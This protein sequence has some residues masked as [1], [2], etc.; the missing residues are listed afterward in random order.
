MFLPR[1]YPD[2]LVGSLL[3]RAER[4]LG[5]GREQL[6]MRLTSHPLSS[7][8][9]LMTPYAGVADAFGLPL[10]EFLH[11]HTVFPYMTAFLPAPERARAL[12]VLVH[13]ADHHRRTASLVRRSVMGKTW[14]RFCPQCV[15]EE[16][17]SYGESYWHRVHQV[18]GVEVCVKHDCNLCVTPFRISRDPGIA[19]PHQVFDLR[20]TCVSIPRAIAA[21]VARASADALWARNGLGLLPPGYP[22]RVKELGYVYMRSK[23]HGALLAHDLK[24]FFGEQYLDKYGC[25]VGTSR[26]GLWPAKLLHA[27]GHHAT[28][29]KHIL[30][31]VFLDS[32]PAPS[33]SRIEFEGRRKPKPRDWSQVEEDAITRMTAEVARHKSAGTRISLEDLHHLAGVSSIV[34]VHWHR[35]PRLMAWLDDFRITPQSARIPGRRPRK[36]SLIPIRLSEGEMYGMGHRTGYCK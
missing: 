31:A 3:H 32:V 14:L 36:D 18:T 25:A 13:A 20:S 28:T 7:H 34:R 11:Q 21:A 4:Q 5:I 22:E 16:L 29:F 9:F 26:K 19:P 12:S 15:G 35:V 24:A 2:E 30:F 27:S 17:R 6:L 33:S 10:E 8:S 1:P 23:T